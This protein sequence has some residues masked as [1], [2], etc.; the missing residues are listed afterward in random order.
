MISRKDLESEILLDAQDYQELALWL[1]E[2]V[3]SLGA[4][5]DNCPYYGEWQ[6]ALDRGKPC[7]NEPCK[8]RVLRDWLE[9][10]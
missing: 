10:R 8:V 1:V 7:P 4:I 9:G 5:C 3:P 2:M 6:D